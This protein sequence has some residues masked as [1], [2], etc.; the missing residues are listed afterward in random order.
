MRFPAHIR[1]DD[2]GRTVQSATDHCRKTAEY[3]GKCLRDVGLEQ[4]GM[5]AGLVHD[6][7]K[8]KAEFA[9]YLEDS[10]AV[11]G[12]VNHTFAGFRLLM[13]RYHGVDAT[14]L[15]AI[16]AELLAL[17][18]GGHHGLFD[19]LDE[20]KKSGISHRMTKNDI[21]YDE[22]RQNFLCQ[23]ASAAELDERFARAHAELTP[24]YDRISNL[25]TDAEE[26]A[27]YL[28][29]LSRLLLSAVIEGDRR[30]TAEF[31]VGMT[32]PS[33]P[34][35]MRLFWTPYLKRLEHLLSGFSQN[36]PIQ[37]ARSEISLRCHAFAEKR[38]GIYRLNVPTGAG[39]TLSS[40]RY[41]LAHGQA[42]GKRRLIF[43]SPLLAILEQNA[44]VLRE[45]LGDDD[46]I[47]EHHSNVM[48]TEEGNRLDP[49]ELAVESWNAPVIITTLVQLLNTLFDGKTT[50]IRRFQGLCNSVI[51]IDEVQTVPPKMLSLFNLALDFLSEVCGATVLLCS[52]TQPCLEKTPHPLHRCRGDIVPYDEALWKP[53]RRT[54]IVDAGAR[55]LEEIGE[56][57]L[58]ILDGAQS[59]LVVCNKKDE[60]VYLFRMLME[61]ADVSCHLSASMCMTHR[62]E[63]LKRLEDALNNGRKCLCVA[64]QV[65]EAG[66]DISFDRVIRLSAGMDSVIQSAG[67][68]NRHG[69]KPDPSPVYVIPCLG[70]K[71]GMLRDIRDAKQATDSLLESWRR[72]PGQFDGD[73]SSDKAIGWYYR[74]LYTSMPVD[75]PNFC[76]QRGAS[77]FELLSCNFRYFDETAAYS[78]KYCMNQAFR[79][80]GSLF[81]VFENDTL[82]VIVPY[83]DGAEL[84]AELTGTPHPDPR[85]LAQWLRRARPY[86]VAVYDWQL[87][88]LGNAVTEHSGIAVLNA[89]FYD[90]ETGLRLS[91]N[92]NEFL[93]V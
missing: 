34:D 27:F 59:L 58:D 16:T 4:A 80:A 9:R 1:E 18:V 3:A 67:R 69:E 77:L 89:D 14:T 25:T 26:C 83:G 40:L 37:K 44:A 41:A 28:G 31:M 39:K 82:D 79:T 47:L 38:G 72:N 24:I 10:S 74:K 73:L 12:S 2:S 52:A 22:S 54:T 32:P 88:K 76:V 81:Q 8:F 48:H 60:A 7:G 55:T 86:A 11:R 63:T 21:H 71:L 45:F 15:E 65:I 20:D 35:D 29:L 51:V 17:A 30:D 85:F 56:F 23:C 36:T 93:E 92:Q 6:C 19:C 68:C 87:Q 57:A 53:F 49:R 64:T 61:H 33:V 62:Q 70:E 91:P 43:V 78:G 50:S 75:Y 46:I 84:I 42:W 66:V 90:E 5:L 13:E